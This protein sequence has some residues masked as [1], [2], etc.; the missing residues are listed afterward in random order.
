LFIS[1]KLNG[2]AEQVNKLWMSTADKT[3]SWWCIKT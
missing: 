1:V 3:M 2:S